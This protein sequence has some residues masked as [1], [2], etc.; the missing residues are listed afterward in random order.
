MLTVY[1][2]IGR[3][4]SRSGRIATLPV[5]PILLVL[6]VLSVAMP[7][8][9][10]AVVASG[11]LSQLTSPFDCI[12]EET[13]VVEGNACGTL[14]NAGTNNVFQVQLSPDG[15]NAY[16]VSIN[17]DLIEYS[18]N[19][20]TG[21]LHVI[22][23][24]TAG[25]DRC[26]AEHVTENAVEV[27]HP[28]AIALSP[29]GRNAYVTGTAKDAVVELERHPASGLL[30]LMNGGKACVTEEP[31]GECEV[32]SAKGLH[33]PYGVTVSPGGESVYVTAVKG[34]AVAELARNTLT[35]VLEPMSGSECI[36]GPTSGCPIETVSG[37]FEPI[38]VIVSPDG[39]NVYVAAG[40]EG[41]KGA[42]V[43]FERESGGALKQ[44]AG[45]EG[46]ISEKIVP[47]CTAGVA[48]QGSEDLVISPD[49]KNVYATS[50]DENAI[51][52]LERT[53]PNGALKQLAAPNACVSTNTITG[54]SKAALTGDTRGVAVS[55][56][57]KDVYVGS[58]GENGVAAF[59][60][61]GAGALEQLTEPAACVTS[62]ASG[63]G[64]NE[65]LGLKETRR[66]AI[67][68][69][70]T[71]VYVAGQA[72]GAIVELARTITPAVS[73][74]NL[75][76]GSLK[77]EQDVYI[78][79]SGFSEDAGGVKVSFGGT[80]SPEVVVTS[81]ST[82][83]AKSPAFGKEES[84]P[85]KVENE[86]GASAEL[87]GD[88]FTYTDKPIVAG[89]TPSAGTETGG[90]TV[91]ITGSGFEAASTV[92]FG[93]VA[94]SSFTV[95]SP[96]SIVATSP[97][98]SGVVDVT[99]ATPQG[100]SAAS[101]ADK[102]AY[103]RGSLTPTGN[104]LF[105]EGYCATQG[106]THVTLENEGDFSG[107]G[108]AYD[109]WACVEPD[110]TEAPIANTGSVLSM[111][112]ACEVE[113]PG[114]TTYAYPSEPNGAYSWECYEVVPPE[115]SQGG[116]GGPAQENP[117]FTTRLA[118]ELGPTTSVAPAVPSP[119]LAK[120]GNVAPVSGTVLV[121][122]PGS[123]VFVALSTL[124]QIPFGTVIEATHGHVSVT[125]ALP[126]GGTQTGEFF[127]GEF[128]LRQGHN[129]VVVAELAGGNFSVCPTARE[130]SHIARARSHIARASSSHTSGSHVVRKL[131][132]NAHGKFSTKGNYAAGAVQ[133][134]EWLTEDLCDG[135]LIRVTRDKVAVTNLV[136]HRH[137]EVRTGHHYLAKA[138]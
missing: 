66:V 92:R 27:S 36:G 112:N 128:I 65:V 124:Q 1:P 17:G 18:R 7:A 86:A 89:V 39:K 73:R 49:E 81:A 82:L 43:A 130:R 134:T 114:V 38:G 126:G 32:K 15:H 64:A 70:G 33:E 121:K 56:D 45:K 4:A 120:T 21:A 123:K 44:I 23:C 62:N 42:V 133:G 113:N 24:I 93:S 29:D 71:N 22:G 84:V 132:A 116:R 125:T 40:A 91:T 67:S 50:A 63:C 2:S 25:T 19:L 79:G 88:R 37:M 46:C 48:V 87:P 107:P 83:R 110:G 60:R 9:A 6:A 75:A 85:V 31:G 53:G 102:F 95:Q 117:L 96:E 54:C 51:V 99:V 14:V 5:V 69:D 12:G 16:S 131:W 72:A 28:S 74:V 26:A 47:E 100:V 80:P 41:E 11:A 137:V 52:E 111:A 109:N 135:T 115:E 106:D 57:G 68:P 127:A 104:G 59:A 55:P 97:P 3:V 20:A 119:V 122:L 58:A 10:E 34:E 94:A 118:S 8:H 35:G 13:G 90:T 101:A 98:G 76:H 61:N 105:L 129:G 108:F 138:P 77:G 30:T 78:K 103:V 136:N